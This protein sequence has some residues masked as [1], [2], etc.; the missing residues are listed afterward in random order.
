MAGSLK[1]LAAIANVVLDPDPW[2]KVDL[3]CVSSGAIDVEYVPSL[4][5]L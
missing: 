4:E 5:H 2:C 1:P 3:E